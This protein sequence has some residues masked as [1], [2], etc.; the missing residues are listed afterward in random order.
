M[1]IRIAIADSDNEYIDRLT[2]VLETYDDVSL[3]I[4]TDRYALE[5]ALMTKSFD[6]LLFSPELFD[7]QV[8]LASSTV[9]VMFLDEEKPV[10]Q[11]CL[12]F[13]K[14]HKYQRIS[15]MYQQ[16]L[17]LYA[18]VC[19]EM[20]QGVLGQ[21][22][23]TMIAFYSPAGGVGKTTASL[24]AAAKLAENGNRTLYL[25]MEEIAAEDYYLSQNGT[26]GVSDLLNTLGSNVNFT[27]KVQSI[28]QSKSE[29][30]YYFNHFSSPGD[31]NEITEEEI[32]ELLKS[33][34]RSG[35]FDFIIIDMSVVMSHK[36][37]V[38]FEEVHKIVLVEKPDVTAARKMERFLAQM[39]IFNEYKHKMSRLLNFDMGRKYE[40][41]ME[42]PRIG[43]LPYIPN[44]DTGQLVDILIRNSGAQFIYQL[45]GDKR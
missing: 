8:S 19:G 36:L 11:S 32:T 23:V 27:M 43:A 16:I 1:L 20:P 3:S 44:P 25:N 17:E 9:T 12:S 40:M 42:I 39:Y 29:N 5:T 15:A 18:E 13:A 38:L 26:K 41:D 37:N 21:N 31:F 10:P 2:N 4:Y 33:L 34:E 45:V 22:G 30:F 14:V 24:V 28:L 7:G 35:L 6:V